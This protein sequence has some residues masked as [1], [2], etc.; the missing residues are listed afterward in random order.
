MKLNLEEILTAVSSYNKIKHEKFNLKTA[1]RLSRLFDT[2]TE[3]Q[4]RYETLVRDALI[5][6]SRKDE[7]GNP[8]VNTS[9]KGESVEILPEYQATFKAE[10]EDLNNNEIE[11]EDCFFTFEDFG[12]LTISIEEIQGLLPF[13]K[14][15]KQEN[16]E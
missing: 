11:I 15:E 7:N 5:K 16:Q 3:E 9:E 6:Y 14:D 8:I 4:V 1:Y 10:M 12:N 13:I 2:L